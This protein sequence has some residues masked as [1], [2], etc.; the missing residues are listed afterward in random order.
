MNTTLW[1]HL[2]ISCYAVLSEQRLVRLQ[3][4]ERLWH[5]YTRSCLSYW[6]QPEI[7]LNCSFPPRLC[8][9]Q[10]LGPLMLSKE[11]HRAR[12]CLSQ[13]LGP[14]TLSLER[15]QKSASATSNWVV[16]RHCG[17]TSQLTWPA[18]LSSGRVWRI[19]A[20]SNTPDHIRPSN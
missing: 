7:D 12:L 3:S 6:R 8:L 16:S 17:V 15:H 14:L 4:G 10:E 1:W 9:S 13:E 19:C 5:Y 11:K 2:V 18:P 20:W